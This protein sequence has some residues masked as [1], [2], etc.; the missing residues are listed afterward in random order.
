[1]STSLEMSA[2][3]M[4]SA[5]VTIGV[6]LYNHS[7][8]IVECLDSLVR[9]TYSPIEIIVVDDGSTDDSFDIAREFLQSQS[10]NSRYEIITRPN[11]GMC[12]TMNEIAQ[13]AQGDFISYI[14]SDDYWMPEKITDQASYL[15]ANPGV[16]LVHSCSV[17]VSDT[18]QVIGELNYP[19]KIKSGYL[20]DDLVRGKAKI[21]T[22]SHLYRR[23]LFDSIGYYDPAFRFEDTDFWLRLTKDH[24]VGFL[25]KVHCSYRWHGEN[26]SSPKNDLVFYN[27]ELLAIYRKNV[28]DPRL[29][30][31]ALR[32]IHKKAMK[33][34]WRT[35]QRKLAAEQLVQYLSPSL[36]SERDASVKE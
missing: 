8:Y 17:R 9:Q 19:K 20:F 6:P 14:G 28:S 25:D 23:S 1:M 18:G 16:A 12:N 15:L 7:R 5:L 34:A 33:T 2:R 22:T 26:L 27:D 36:V 31:T 21:N 30:K 10:L 35:G 11:R 24:K 4:E 29:L 32:K 13:K 3:N